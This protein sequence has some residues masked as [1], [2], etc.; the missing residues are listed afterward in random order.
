ML[1]ILQNGISSSVTGRL[2][3]RQSPTPSP[4]HFN[5]VS[6]ARK[7][8]FED[9]EM[10]RTFSP[11]SLVGEGQRSF[12]PSSLEGEGHREQL[13]D[14]LRRLQKLEELG[15]AKIL[16]MVSVG[17]LRAHALCCAI[18]WYDDLMTYRS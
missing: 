4:T 1:C 15:H 11:P 7:V 18:Y 16:S 10:G 6:P 2:E 14:V 3:G 12:P 9:R 17:S 13:Q 5:P 8:Q